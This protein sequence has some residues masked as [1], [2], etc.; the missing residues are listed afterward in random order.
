MLSE[1]APARKTKILGRVLILAGVAVWIPYLALKLAGREPELLYF[2]PFH[3]MGV[4]P[5][6][7]LSRWRQLKRLVGPRSAIDSIK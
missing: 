2:L 6:A 7:V 5:G 1:N 3:L 4:I